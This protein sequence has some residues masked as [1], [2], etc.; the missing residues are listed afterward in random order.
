MVLATVCPLIF[1]GFIVR[2]LAIFAFFAFLNTRLLDT[3]VLKY[4]RVKYSQIYGVSPY[5]IVVCG[6]CRV[7]NLLDSLLG[8]FEDV[9]EWRATSEDFTST[10]RYGRL[11]LEKGLV[12]PAKE[13]T[14]KIRSL[15][16]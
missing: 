15:L 8:S 6:S 4:S 9:I 3:V 11:S 7:K 1:A 14:E 5:T 2:G 16:Q 13:A 12:A 10:R